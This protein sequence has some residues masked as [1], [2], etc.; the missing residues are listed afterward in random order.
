MAV[1]MFAVGN[2]LLINELAMRL[3]TRDG[4]PIDILP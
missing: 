2:E 1:E 4:L 3:L